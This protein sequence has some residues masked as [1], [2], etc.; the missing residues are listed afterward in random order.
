MCDGLGTHGIIRTYTYGLKAGRPF[1]D[2][3]V[4]PN[5]N[6]TAQQYKS[7]KV[8]SSICHIFEKV[9]KLKDLM[10]TD[11][12]RAEAARRHQIVVDFLYHFFDEEDAPE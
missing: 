10:L 9:L 2:R 4:F 12:G 11:A 3:A 6:L 5:I 1:F 7:E 8:G